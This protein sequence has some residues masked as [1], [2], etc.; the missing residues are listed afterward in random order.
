MFADPA[1]TDNGWQDEIQAINP[2]AGTASIWHER[3]DDWSH[4][5]PI[6]EQSATGQ[7][8]WKDGSYQVTGYPYN[9][10]MKRDA[11][12]PYYKWF[13]VGL[14]PAS[15]LPAAPPRTPWGWCPG[16]YAARGFPPDRMARG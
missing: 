6:D 4:N 5:W 8:G 13:T 14:Q 11:D 2:P 12:T 16:C 1:T 7:S 15:Q 9:L 10:W 3:T